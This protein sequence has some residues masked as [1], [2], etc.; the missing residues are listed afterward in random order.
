MT[1]DKG[2]KTIITE[3]TTI[4]LETTDVALIFHEDAQMSLFIPQLEDDDTVPSHVI[5]LTMIG[6]LLA[7]EDQELLDLIDRKLDESM[8][9][10]KGDKEN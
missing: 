10:I 3:P 5:Y 2:T 9:K 1:K 8:G 6:A 7:S 4:E